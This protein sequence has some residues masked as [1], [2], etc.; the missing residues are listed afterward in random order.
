MQDQ[1]SQQDDKGRNMISSILSEGVP[2]SPKSQAHLLVAGIAALVVVICIGV[3]AAGSL[4]FSRSKAA[5]DRAVADKQIAEALELALPVSEKYPAAKSFLEEHA[6]VSLI[7]T[8]MNT[9]MITA[10]TAGAEADAA[11]TWNTAAGAAEM[12]QTAYHDC[13][14]NKASSLAE[15]ARGGFAQ[16]EQEAIAAQAAKRAAAE[17]AA[18]KAIADAK[19]KAEA[20]AKAAAA[21]AA[22]A[23]AAATKPGTTVAK[24]GAAGSYTVKKG[25]SLWLIGKNHG[26][27]VEDLKKLNNLKSDKIMPGQVLV[28]GKRAGR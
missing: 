9:A 14:F 15:S 19:A 3:W 26:V 11:N 8:E 22:A 16:A 12:A 27:S 2:T 4:R 10:Q 28:L 25:D 21:K 17:A 18:A 23:K 6:K 24:A 13:D 1:K 7:L 20:E 5:F